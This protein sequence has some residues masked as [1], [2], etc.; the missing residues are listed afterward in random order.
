MA[1]KYYVEGWTVKQAVNVMHYTIPMESMNAIM[2]HFEFDGSW[3]AYDS[4]FCQ[5]TQD[6]K[7]Y[8]I[9]LDSEGDMFVPSVLTKGSWA[10][11]VFGLCSEN[12]NK[13]Y[14]T[15]GSSLVVVAGGYRGNGIAPPPVIEDYYTKLFASMQETAESAKEAAAQAAAHEKACLEALEEFQ[16]DLSSVTEAVLEQVYK[17]VYT[18]DEVYNKE[19]IDGEVK[20]RYN[21]DLYEESTMTSEEIDAIIGG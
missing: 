12:T 7:T 9:M 21:Q 3:K 1:L 14:T 2:M 8:N 19:E 6:G 15:I 17:N 20:E 13:R 18:K 10:V 5:L 4:R 11:S 16:W